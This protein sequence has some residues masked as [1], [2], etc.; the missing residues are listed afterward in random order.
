MEIG[1]RLLL[2]KVPFPD[3][4]Q[5]V[6]EFIA[7]TVTEEKSNVTDMWT[8]EPKHKGYKAVGENGDEFQL[9]WDQFPS[10]S[11]TPHY[12]WFNT[13][14]KEFWYDV[15]YVTHTTEILFTPI[16]LQRY[17][18]IAFCEIHGQLYYTNNEIGCF[19]C[20][21]EKE[22]KRPRERQIH[23]KGWR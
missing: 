3:R 20:Y 13:T 21:M 5:E 17:N 7:I 16:F 8:G 10:D 15:V 23:W 22:Y 2:H 9:N 6:D 19:D 18:F 12:M 14:R 11:M 1:E 4:S